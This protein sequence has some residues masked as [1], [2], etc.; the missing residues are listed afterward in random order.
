MPVSKAQIRRARVIGHTVDFG[1]GVEVKFWYDRNKITDAWMKDWTLQEEQ[2]N[3]PRMNEMLFDLI[4]RWDVVEEDGGPEVPVTVE[5]I[6][7]LFSWPD[8]IYLMKE[9]MTGG[10]PSSEEGNGSSEP[11]S[12]PV[13]TSSDQAETSPNGPQPSP[14]PAPLASPSPT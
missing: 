3:A 1:E 2:A 4:N 12:S 5:T 9:L 8:K 6:A 7:E 13:A 11:S 14:L 10:L